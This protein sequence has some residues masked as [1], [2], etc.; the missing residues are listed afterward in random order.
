MAIALNDQKQ[1]FDDETG[2][3]MKDKIAREHKDN[4]LVSVMLGLPGQYD[5]ASIAKT[6]PIGLDQCSPRWLLYYREARM[7]GVSCMKMSN[8]Y[9][10]MRL[11]Y[12]HVME[13]HLIQE[14]AVDHQI[15]YQAQ[16]IL[17]DRRRAKQEK[18]QQ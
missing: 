15:L 13:N 14:R 9:A 4:C 10:Y 16:L 6:V 18:G 5:W 7:A 1:L 12:Q 8:H 2:E 11:A 3:L 17:D